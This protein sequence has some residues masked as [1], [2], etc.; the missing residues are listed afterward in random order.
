MVIEPH[1][2]DP[3]CFAVW[4]CLPLLHWA[5]LG[6]MSHGKSN[7]FQLPHLA[8]QICNRRLNASRRSAAKVRAPFNCV[9][10]PTRKS[11]MKI[12]TCA[13]SEY[14]LIV[15]PIVR[16]R[17]RPAVV[18]RAFAPN[19]QG[20]W[21]Q[22]SVESRPVLAKRTTNMTRACPLPWAAMGSTLT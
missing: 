21:L 19:R 3:R 18:S 17:S 5:K 16:H 1:Q 13:Y 2:V 7:H 4:R 6:D 20:P 15:W 12:R 14:G 22:A 9:E 10:M 8:S 11:A